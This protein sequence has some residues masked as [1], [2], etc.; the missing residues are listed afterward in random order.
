MFRRRQ[1]K[2]ATDKKEK[3]IKVKMKTE[4]SLFPS[5]Y[6]MLAYNS[7]FVCKCKQFTKHQIQWRITTKENEYNKLYA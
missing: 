4:L 5:S 7:V 2:S 6:K 1:R 3:L